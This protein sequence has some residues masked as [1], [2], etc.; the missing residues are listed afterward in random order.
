MRRPSAKR[1]SSASRAGTTRPRCSTATLKT[2]SAMRRWRAGA[3]PSPP[4]RRFRTSSAASSARR[5]ASRGA[6]CASSSRISAA[7]SATSRT[8][9]YEPLC[10]FLCTQVGGRLVKL[11]VSR[12]ET[13]VCNRVR[14]AIRSHIITYVRPDG[15]F[16]ARRLEAFSKQGA[17]ASHGHG[18]VA[19]GAGGVRPAVQERGVQG[20]RLHGVYEHAGGRRHAWLRHP[21]GDVRARVP[22]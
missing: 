15:T 8:A 6:R 12:E 17:Y 3:L 1:G 13:F 21:A 11:D 2:T 10:A 14:H 9:L 19:K 7:G 18:I 16:V 5:S 22:H 20:G 4:P